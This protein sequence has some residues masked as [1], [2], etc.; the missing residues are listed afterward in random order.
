M[1]S[2]SQ[3]PGLS[4]PSGGSLSSQGAVVLS[5]KVF[6]CLLIFLGLCLEAYGAHVQK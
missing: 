3:G 1:Q 6:P 2:L 5:G 4:G